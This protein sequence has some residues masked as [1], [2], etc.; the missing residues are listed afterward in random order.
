[1]IRTYPICTAHS[2]RRVEGLRSII[3]RIEADV[4]REPKR[5]IRLAAGA[6][7]RHGILS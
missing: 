6:T 3:R 7:P 5:E 2:H 4:A 1:M